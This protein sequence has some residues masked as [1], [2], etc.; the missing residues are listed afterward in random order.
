MAAIN[1]SKALTICSFVVDWFVF[2]CFTLG[3]QPVS[4]HA[5][6]ENVWSGGIV[7]II[8]LRGNKSTCPACLITVLYVTVHWCRNIQF[9]AIQSKQIKHVPASCAMY[10][11]VPST[12]WQPSGSKCHEAHCYDVSAEKTEVERHWKSQKLTSHRV[13]S[14]SSGFAVAPSRPYQSQSTSPAMQSRR[15]KCQK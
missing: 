13:P 7:S 10:W 14:P 5:H 12:S 6:C 2:T 11:S 9:N 4:N 1:C 3:L 15:N 8:G